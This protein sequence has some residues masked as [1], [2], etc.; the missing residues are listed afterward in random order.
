MSIF[1]R[2]QNN[3]RVE[4]EFQIK[5]KLNRL[6]CFLL[7]KRWGL[8]PMRLDNK[9]T[10]RTKGRSYKKNVYVFSKTNNSMKFTRYQLKTLKRF[11]Y[12]LTMKRR[13]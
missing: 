10:K 3:H 1:S 4:K 12:T 11:N 7:E 8:S 13:Y 2:N 6:A 9:Q 5:P